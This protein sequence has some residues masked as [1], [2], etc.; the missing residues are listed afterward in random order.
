MSRFLANKPVMRIESAKTE[1]IK[2]ND[3]SVKQ[4]QTAKKIPILEPGQSVNVKVISQDGEKIL[5]KDAEGKIF[6][7]KMLSDFL[8]SDGDTIELMVTEKTDGRMVLQIISAE[9]KNAAAHDILLGMGLQGNRDAA[10]IVQLFRNMQIKPTAGHIAASLGLMQEDPAMDAEAAVFFTVNNLPVTRECK[11]AY[12]ALAK[13]G[14]DLGCELLTLLRELAPQ[15]GAGQAAQNVQ[16]GINEHHIADRILSLFMVLDGEKNGE[17]IKNA[18]NDLQEKLFSLKNMIRNADI[19]DSMAVESKVDELLCRFRLAVQTKGFAY[20]QIPLKLNEDYG[21][22]ELYVYKRKKHR[23]KTDAQ[24][25][26]IQLCLSMQNIGRMEAL[27]RVEE[28]NVTIL[29]KL[30]KESFMQ[31]VKDKAVRLY[32]DL[33]RIGYHLSDTKV[34]KL[35]KNTTAANAEEILAAASSRVPVYLDYRI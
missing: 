10:D 28:K 20:I 2:I 27:I 22:A 8:F 16:S 12:A 23:G 34:Q 18:G 15:T 17:E 11:E 29:F 31:A 32:K 21:T 7:A 35:S 19:K 4:R 3:L 9:S 33:Q 6:C 24:N 26:T 30:E 5:L 25:T 14:N 13:N 1:L